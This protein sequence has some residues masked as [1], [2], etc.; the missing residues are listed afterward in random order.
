MFIESNVKNNLI[1]GFIAGIMMMSMP[2]PMPSHAG[3][4]EKLVMPGPVIKGHAKFEDTCSECH[5][6]FKK[7]SQNG[8]CVACHKDVGKDISKK[9]GFH[10]HSKG[11]G[12]LECKYCHTDHIGRSADV[13]HLDYETF[14]HEVTDFILEG[15]HKKTKCQGCHLAGKKYR[16]AR[17][18]CYSC[19]RQ[20]DRHS[21]QLGKKCDKCH[22]QAA[23]GRA[24][25]DHDKKTKFPLKGSH[26]KV[27]C[28]SCHP[29]DKFKKTPRT[30]I[31]CHSLNDK[32]RGQFGKKCQTCHVEKDWK[33]LV[34][35]HDRDTKFRLIKSHVKV[36]CI[37]CHRGNI[38]KEKLKS[39]CLS[40]HANDDEHKGKFG[41]KCESCHSSGKWKDIHFNHDRDTKFKL[42]DRHQKL[43]CGDCHRQIIADEKLGHLCYDC[44]QQ[45]DVHQGQEGKKCERC[46]NQQN[47]GKSVKFDHSRTRYPLQGLHGLA[48][49]EGCHLTAAY[50]K[51]PS[52]CVD[53]HLKND[54]HKKSLGKECGLCHSPGG[55]GKWK[56]EHDVQADFALIGAHK[57]TPCSGCHMKPAEKEIRL[58]KTCFD[59]HQTDDVHKGQEGKRCERCHNQQEWGGKVKF[60]HDLTHFPLIGMHA[61]AT[62]EDCHITSEF[63]E[64]KSDCIACHL[65]DDE[66]QKRLGTKCALC[67]NSNG[68]DLWEFDHDVQTKFKLDG[69]HSGMAC[70]ACHTQPAGKDLKLP[71][72]CN[73]C[74]Q[75]DD[76][77]RGKFGRQCERCHDTETFQNIRMR[78]FG[79]GSKFN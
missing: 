75:K 33:T 52:D 1:V 15:A 39:N 67:H 58:A 31:S 77:H 16:E 25:F 63:K 38:Y 76:E 61:V 73:S 54:I 65:K 37:S 45:D 24:K 28:D 51:T 64:A 9:Q 19:H 74:H 14:D 68:W 2:M 29:N 22:D 27:K 70:L 69:R 55:W 53:C 34:F 36:T 43:K 48:T 20:D 62:C 4:L 35:D 44:H 5:D 60:D 12:R 56:F 72:T 59:C 7:N 30:C 66:H 42:I 71:M 17:H 57:N 32:H 23:W 11:L 50:K 21:G 26:K 79:N 10:G 8:K 18:D 41:P 47:W 3:S 13:I 40:C 6:L 78:G 46:H 49:C